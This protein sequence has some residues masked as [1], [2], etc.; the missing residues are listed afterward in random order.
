MFSNTYVMGLVCI[1]LGYCF[2][3]V[4]TAGIVVKKRYNTSVFE[5]GS[6][7]PGM[8]NV[9]IEYG[10][11]PAYMVVAGDAIKVIIPTII[12]RL[13]FPD[14]SYMLTTLLV[15]LGSTLGHNYPFWH[16]FKGGEGVM[17][18]CT[19]IILASPGYGIL[20][21]LLGG[22]FVLL[23][24]FLNPAAVV[25]CL[26]FSLFTYFN[27]TTAEFI[28]TVI[29]TVMMIIAN[30]ACIAKLFTDQREGEKVDVGGAIMRA[31]KAK[32]SKN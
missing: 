11:K 16:K 30:Y 18:T 22:V 27:G 1:A 13:L 23:T 24:Q 28:I 21:V 12:A 2:G 4:L 26:F 15:G 32:F 7:N 8:A 5:V 6:K 25:I 31:L 10:M 9:A 19:A 29:Y 14:T 17:T 20:S 3:V